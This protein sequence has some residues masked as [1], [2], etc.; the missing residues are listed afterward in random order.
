MSAN[1]M[2]NAWNP[3]KLGKSER[4]GYSMTSYEVSS[5]WYNVQMENGGDRAVRLQR[6]H[7]M[8][9]T[10][11]EI[12]RALDIIAEDISSCNADDQDMLFLDYPDDNKI[13]KST[14]KLLDSMKEMWEKRTGMEENFYTRVRDT[15]KYGAS[16]YR[17]Q[18]DGSLRKLYPERMVGYILDHENEDNVTH[19][20]HDPSIPKIKDRNKNIQSKKYQSSTS[21]ENL[22]I[23]PVSDLVV[24]RIGDGPFGESILERV[25]TV[26]RQMT[27]LE[28]AVVIYRVVRAPER[29]IYYID[30][31]NLQGPKREAQIER[32]RMRLMQK[33]ANKSGKLTTDYDP[34][35]TSEDIF[36]PT[37]STGK[38][39][40][41]ETLPGGQNLGELS[42]VEYFGKKLAAGLRIPYSMIDT[43][44]EQ[45]EQ[46]SDM[47]VGQV[48]QVEMRYMGYVRRFARYFG[49]VLHENFEEFCKKRDVVVPDGCELKITPPMSFALYKDMEVNQSMLN[50]FSSTMQMTSM[51]KKVAMQKYLNMDAEEIAYNEVQKLN[52]MGIDD[53]IIKGMPQHHIDNLV[54]GTPNPKIAE[55]YG[56]DV[57]GAAGGMRF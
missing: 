29:K 53:D 18:V 32:Q 47:R 36:I 31:G 49:S 26:W 37:N 40:R 28:D 13:L 14:L 12:G 54:Y 35:S 50:V 8:D 23:I 39:S 34:H 21:K 10:S 45:G 33:Q 24:F 6:Y 16:F 9:T 2:E 30:V 27:L 56:V 7:E 1:L 15:L 11:V 44:G 4:G 52:E 17:K 43:Q 41:I 57:E 20:I 22:E 46:H 48:Y 55:I 42:D 19:Y 5:S 51:S 38:G 25:F 3:I